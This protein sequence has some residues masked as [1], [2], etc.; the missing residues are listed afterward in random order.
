MSIRGGWTATLLASAALGGCHLGGG[1]STAAPTGQVVAKVG[2]R[3]ITLRELNA[4]TPAVNNP[5][6]RAHKAAQLATLENIVARTVLAKAAVDQGV[7]KTPEFELM[8]Q[9]ALDTLLAQSLENKIAGQVPKVTRDDADRFIA[10]HPDIFAQ[11]KVWAIDQLRMGRPSDPTLIKRLEP[12]KTLSDIEALLNQEKIPFQ[13][14]TGSLDAVGADPRMI[15][16]IT[17][18]PPGEV[19]VIPSNNSLLVNQINDTKVIPFTG[20]QAVDY[21]TQVVTRQ[22]TSDAV[23]RQV[24]AIFGKA[25]A[26]V[27]FNKDFEPPK[28]SAAAAA[29]GAPTPAT[30]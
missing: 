5:D 11:R 22:R 6:P 20:P 18:L 8:K 19:F 17:K 1:G 26:S 2:D 27:H 23:Q 4:E 14:S 16:A 29:P 13:H 25:K 3:E 28:A 24:G 12:L 15:D 7:D 9:R 10:A 21:A 30:K